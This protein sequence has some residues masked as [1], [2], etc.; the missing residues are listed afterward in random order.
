MTVSEAYA[1]GYRSVKLTS[2]SFGWLRR[3]VEKLDEPIPSGTVVTLTGTTLR[4]GKRYIHIP[5]LT[6]VYEHFLYIEDD[7]QVTP[8]EDNKDKKRKHEAQAKTTK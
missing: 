1:L 6:W 7:V 3:G 4:D 5:D 8:C 2:S